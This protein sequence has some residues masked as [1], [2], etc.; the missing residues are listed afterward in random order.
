MEV[1]G[2]SSSCSVVR[3]S[4]K[5]WADSLSRTMESARIPWRMALREERARPSGLD[6]P[7]DLAELA[8]D[9]SRPAM[10][11]AP[12]DLAPLAR[13]ASIRRVEL[14]FICTFLSLA[15]L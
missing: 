11:I 15:S 1:T 3:T 13:E 2:R 7:V 4:E 5:P 10:V 12:C 9:A 14:I 6:G 8:R